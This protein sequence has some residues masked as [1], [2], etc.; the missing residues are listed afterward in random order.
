M[1]QL[2][3]IS[4]A[5]STIDG[6]KC[7]V[8]MNVRTHPLCTYAGYLSVIVLGFNL[9]AIFE[10]RILMKISFLKAFKLRFK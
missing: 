9:T 8:A 3:S 7:D 10:H 5:L 2:S 4:S 6:T 1:D